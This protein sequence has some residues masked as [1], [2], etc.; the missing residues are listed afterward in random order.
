MEQYPAIPR[1]KSAVVKSSVGSLV[2]LPTVNGSVT[3]ELMRGYSMVN[4]MGP[5]AVIKRSSGQGTMI[6]GTA[7]D[8]TGVYVRSG[9][10]LPVKLLNKGIRV[11]QGAKNKQSNEA[12]TVKPCGENKGQGEEEKQ[13]RI[14]NMVI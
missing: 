5:G 2:N 14:I 3:I 4:V 9:G 1:L 11:K 6:R 12:I 10:E 13:R 7:E 8:G